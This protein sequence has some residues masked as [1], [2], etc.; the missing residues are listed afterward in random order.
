MNFTAARLLIIGDLMLDLFRYGSVSRISP[1]APVPVL[2]IDRDVQ[3]LGGAGN[4]LANAFAIG[5][6]ANLIGLVGEDAAGDSCMRLT[7]ELGADPDLLVRRSRRTSTKTRFI[8]AS[9]QLLRCDEEDAS[10]CDADVESEVIAKFDAAVEQHNA[11]AI[12]DYAKGL[13]TDRV[14]SH[15]MERCRALSIPVI[16]DPKRLDFTAYAGATVI[17]PNRSELAAF[18][19]GDCRTLENCHAA[20]RQ[21]IAETGASLLVTLSDEGM[22]LYPRDAEPQH[23]QAAATEVFDVSGAGDTVLA[24][25]TAGIASGMAMEEAAMLANAGAGIVVR[26]LGTATLTKEELARALF[27]EHEPGVDKVSPLPGAIET[28]RRWKAEGLR[29]GFTNG[30]FDIVHS[31]HIASLRQA[32]AR[33]DRLVVG[34]NSDES[35]TRLKG[36]GRPIQ[37]ES[38]RLAVLS[39]IDAVDLVILFG[40]DTP[41]DLIEELRPTDLFKGADYTEDAVVGA[42]IVRAEGGRV[43]LLPLVPG[44]ST[45]GAVERILQSRNAG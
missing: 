27:D 4:V 10:S 3:M 21:A 15:I 18:S 9:Q 19:R 16:V 43:H 12:S 42:D 31:G 33:C 37:E 24:I 6:H 8:S 35:V 30:C 32:R 20:A 29:V 38:S 17:K 26:K 23:F 5:C 34:L 14:L 11:V 22:V 2:T 40:E 25:F 7:E 36:A 41:R 13:L 28:V 45:T 39:A 44:V 1:E